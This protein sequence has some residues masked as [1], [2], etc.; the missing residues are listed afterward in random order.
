MTPTDPAGQ[1]AMVRGLHAPAWRTFTTL[2]GAAGAFVHCHGCDL[3]PHAEDYA[4]WPCR[5]AEI[6]YTADEITALSQPPIRT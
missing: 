2:K 1:I 3:G 4:D 5:T 6:I